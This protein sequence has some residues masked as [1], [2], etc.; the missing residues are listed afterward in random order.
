M[1]AARNSKIS[2]L[3]IKYYQDDVRRDWPYARLVIFAVILWALGAQIIKFLYPDPNI[4]QQANLETALTYLRFTLRNGTPLVGACIV[5]YLYYYM[6]ERG[7]SAPLK[8]SPDTRKK[9]ALSLLHV[10][11][12]FIIGVITFALFFSAYS[13]VKVRIPVFT[14][15]TWDEAFM[16]LDYAIFLGNHPWALFD[17][18]YEHPGL[19]RIIDLLYD[20]WAGLFVTIWIMCFC[21]KNIAPR[22][23]FQYPIALILTWFIGGNILAFLLASGGPCYFGPLTGL[24]DPYADQMLKLQNIH[25]AVPLSAVT[26]QDILWSVY[27]QG[28]LGLGGISAMPSMHC[29]TAFLIVLLSW[30]H[31]VLRIFTFAF[32]IV[33]LISSFVLAWHYAVDGLLAIPIASGAWWLAGRV[34]TLTET[35]LS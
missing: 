4:L 28:A 30:K 26:Y 9:A 22:K 29:A 8:W 21:L 7:L 11:L 34:L 17:W 19:I 27:E 3:A 33:I 35:R 32:F 12:L 20:A 23:R 18:I 1:T 5:F 24:E 2:N 16:K 25:D 10:C 13:T 31:K 15:Y 6:R 14:K